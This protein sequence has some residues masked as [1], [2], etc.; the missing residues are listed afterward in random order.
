MLP[1]VN[2]LSL[3]VEGTI[4]NTPGF[5]FVRVL[6][7]IWCGPLRTTCT[8]PATPGARLVSFRLTDRPVAATAVYGLLVPLPAH[9]RMSCWGRALASVIEVALKYGGPWPK[10]L[11]VP[12]ICNKPGNNAPV[13]GV[14]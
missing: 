3:A 2:R 12:T 10:V 13:G 8:A 6:T 11:A 4:V 1:M 5:G 7:S 9:S 14:G